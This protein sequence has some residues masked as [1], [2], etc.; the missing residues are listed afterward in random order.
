[1]HLLNSYSP[2]SFSRDL[3]YRDTGTFIC[4]YNGTADITS[5]DNSTRVHLY[6]EDDTHLMKHSGVDMMSAVQSETMVLPCEPTH[7]EVKIKL[8]RDGGGEVKMGKF[9]TFDPKVSAM[10]NA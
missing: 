7:P 8:F 10:S 9:V 3:D 4:T 6:V 5:I 2:F 1:L